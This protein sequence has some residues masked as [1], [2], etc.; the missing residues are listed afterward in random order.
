MKLQKLVY[1]SKAWHLVWE[2]KPLFD[3]RTE[4]WANGPV[5]PRLYFK[6]RSQYTISELPDGD[7]EQLTS[8]E[9]E[10]IDIVLG[11]YGEMKAFE[12]S[13]LTHREKPWKDARGDTP[14]GQRSNVE[15]TDQK[16]YEYYDGLVG[17]E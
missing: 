12:L 8:A 9:K 2:T 5:V 10:S 11:H 3:D 1:Y 17:V 4:A 16:L 15:I 14:A 13:D 7:P 6:H